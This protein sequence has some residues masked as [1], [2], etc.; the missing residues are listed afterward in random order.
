MTGELGVKGLPAGADAG[1]MAQNEFNPG[2][3]NAALLVK[4]RFSKVYENALEQPVVT[5]LKLKVEAIPARMTAV[6]GVGAAE[7]DGGA[8]G[9]EIEVEATLRP[10][11][12]EA[13]MVRVKVAVPAELQPGP[14]R[15]VVS[16]G[17]TVDRLMTRTASRS[18]GRWGWRIRWRS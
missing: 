14:M 9:R 10:Y 17:A 12:A 16:D 13:R 7:Q 11:Q 8:G 3:I 15:V 2:T 18:S 5:G 6:H 4:D 1:L